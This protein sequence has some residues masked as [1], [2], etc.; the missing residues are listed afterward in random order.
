MNTVM[1]S[2]LRETNLLK[3]AK[4]VTMENKKVL[5]DFVKLI[6]AIADK[7]GMYM[8]NNVEDLAL[9]IWGYKRACNA[10]DR[11]LLENLM[12]DFKKS[13]NERFE[14]KEVVEWVRLIR[15]YGFGDSNTLS[16]FK[17]AFNDFIFSGYYKIIID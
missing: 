2:L 10:R 5:A 8:V 9:V 11:E 1:E 3:G 16:L 7:P 17:L 13:V 4:E 14:T 6:N 12:D 15:F